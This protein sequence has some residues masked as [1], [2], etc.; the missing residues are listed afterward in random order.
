MRV[1][2][3]RVKESKVFVDG[4]QISDINAGLLIYLGISHDDTEEDLHYMVKKIIN[5]RIFPNED[6]KMDKS[7][8][9]QS[10]LELLVISQF[11]L[12]GSCKKGNRPSFASA[13]LPEKAKLLYES[14]IQ[15][16]KKNI[17]SV[18]TGVF[19]ADMKIHSINDGPVTFYMDSKE[20]I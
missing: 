11:T 15:E 9:S 6:G 14:F 8:L 19:G 7:I 18:K 10:N 1:I 2:I 17:L 20:K 5:L 13:A 12:F 3:Q 16:C 4:V